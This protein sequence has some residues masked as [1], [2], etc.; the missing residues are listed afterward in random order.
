MFVIVRLPLRIYTSPSLPLLPYMSEVVREAGA[1]VGEDRG[2]EPAVNGREANIRLH[3]PW[4]L[5]GDRSRR[6]DQHRRGVTSW[7]ASEGARHWKGGNT[8]AS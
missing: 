3:R 6:G 1:V 5:S 8:L 7:R 2:T 4:C